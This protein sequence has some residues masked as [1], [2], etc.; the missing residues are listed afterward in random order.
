MN[1]ALAGDDEN[2]GGE[3]DDAAASKGITSM[4]AYSELGKQTATSL[5]LAAEYASSH[6]QYD[7]A[8]KLCRRALEKDY[9]D[10]DLHMTYA[11]ALEEKLKTQKERDHELLNEC[12]KEWLIVLRTEVGDEAGLSFHGISPFGHW[13]QDEDRG[14]PARSH[15]VSLTGRAPRPWETDAKFLKWLNRPSAS[16]AGRLLS[17]KSSNNTETVP[18]KIVKVE[19]EDDK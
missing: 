3:S 7:Q 8:I 17:K 9:N 2:V 5:E 1:I 10:L 18:S 6:G 11:G 15:L 12:V 13:Y 4:E 14:I 16:V 19:A